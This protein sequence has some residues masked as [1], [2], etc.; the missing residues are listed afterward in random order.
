MDILV[1]HRSVTMM[2]QTMQKNMVTAKSTRHWPSNVFEAIIRRK[3]SRTR[4]REEKCDTSKPE[5]LLLL[6]GT[7]H[8]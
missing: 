5:A 6:N 8:H 1:Q 2:K 7:T 4:R 3:G